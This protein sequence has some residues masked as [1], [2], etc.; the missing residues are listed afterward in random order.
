MA[1]VR[2]LIADDHEVVRMGLRSLVET[3]RGYAVCGEASDGREAV[4][5]AL[6][7]EPDLVI[8]DVGLPVL[9]GL[10]AARQILSMKRQPSILVH[11]EVASESI[12]QQALQMGIRGFI[13]KRDP[14]SYVLSAA[15]AL[16]QGRTFF[17]SSMTEMVLASAKRQGLE[18]PL[19]RRESEILQLLAEGNCSKDIGAILDLSTKTVETHRSNLMQKLRLHSIV[20]LT[21]YAVRT[22]IIQVPCDAGSSH[23]LSVGS[24]TTHINNGNE[25][26]VGEVMAPVK[27][28]SPCLAM[29]K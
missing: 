18:T 1:A 13:L 4:K 27:T 9:N 7:L 28:A 6:Q 2:V 17:T 21:L 22:G 24:D 12:M 19:T 20:E 26:P 10:E 15:E 8:L 25:W 29:P 23:S 16:M 11:T 5:F 3:G 14:G